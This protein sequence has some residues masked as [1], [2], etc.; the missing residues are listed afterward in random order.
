M[1]LSWA[2][3]PET[4]M[5]TGPNNLS[6]AIASNPFYRMFHIDSDLRSC[7]NVIC[8]KLRPNL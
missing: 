4:E 6:T 3:M 8:G 5:S 7:R 2:R 1:D